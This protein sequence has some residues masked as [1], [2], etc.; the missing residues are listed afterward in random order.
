MGGGRANGFRKKRKEGPHWDSEF[1]K[2]R[3]F[4][5]QNFPVKE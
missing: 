1:V 4:S 2:R 5:Q 3:G